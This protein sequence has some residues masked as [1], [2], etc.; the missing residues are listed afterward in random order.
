MDDGDVVAGAW[1][2]GT[3]AGLI[4][5]IPTYQELIKC[6]MAK[7]IVLQYLLENL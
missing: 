6:I 7:A 1:A 2:C 5:N 3:V 4:N